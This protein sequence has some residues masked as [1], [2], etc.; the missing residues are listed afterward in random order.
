[1]SSNIF[2]VY[3]YLDPM[4]VGLYKY[5]DFEFLYEPFYIG[6]GKGNRDISHLTQAKKGN[7]VK[8]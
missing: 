7:Y 4:K 1:M 8:I 2:Y 3:V 5:G 6:K